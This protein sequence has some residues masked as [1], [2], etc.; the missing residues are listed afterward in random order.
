M[1]SV[2]IPVALFFLTCAGVQAQ[3]PSERHPFE[4]VPA[5]EAPSNT[6]EFGSYDARTGYPVAL[7]HLDDHTEGNT[8]ELR[9]KYWLRQ[10]AL[11]LGLS[12]PNLADL[13]LK[14]VRNGQ[15]GSNV[16][17][18]QSHLGLPVHGAEVVVNLDRKG[19]V[20]FVSSSY[21]TG[22][23][24]QLLPANMTA[25]QARA[26]A[27]N[28][29]G[30]QGPLQ[31]DRNQQVV[32]THGDDVRL[33][34]EVRLVGAEPI[35]DWEAI[36]DANTG[37]F[38]VLQDKSCYLHRPEGQGPRPSA[39]GDYPECDAYLPPAAMATGTGFV[40]D[41]DPLSQVATAYAGAYVDGSDA[42]NA[43]LNAS[44]VSRTLNDITLTG[45]TYSLEGPY[46]AIR[47]FEAPAKGLFAQASPT[48]NFD[49]AA[50]AFEGVNTY[51][52]IDLSMRYLNATLG[53]NV[54]P[55][56][57]ATGVQF[58]AHGLNGAD[59]S[60][61]VG[62]TGRLAFGEGGVDDAE[63]SDVVLHE[64]GHGLHDWITVGGLSN[65]QG[66][67]EGTGDYWTMSHSRSLAQWTTAQAAYHWVFNWDG[68][69]PFWGGRITNY[70]AVYPGGLTGAI[71]T[72]GQIWS[73][74][75]MKIYD[76]IG[77]APTDVALWEGLAMT[78]GSTNQ[79]SAAIA[80]RQAAINMGYTSTQINTI[81]SLLSGCG[82]VLP[83]ILS[84]S[85]DEWTATRANPSEVNLVWSTLAESGNKMFVVERRLE[86]EADFA[87]VARVDGAGDANTKL[88]Y[89][90][91]DPNAFGGPS[92]Y[93]LR[94]IDQDGGSSLS[95]TRLVEGSGFVGFEARISPN[96]SENALQLQISH[97]H[98]EPIEMDITLS[99]LSGRVLARESG[100]VQGTS[101]VTLFQSQHFPAGVYQ[102]AVELDGQRNVLRWV[103]R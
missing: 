89:S 94:F 43:S 65:V 99:D 87:E 15:S 19:N 61:Y 33:A 51:Y 11:R 8:P 27:I 10:N 86:T 73:T 90:L 9:A 97:T 69:N 32:W 48:F 93:R 71:H 40:F 62:G 101:Q 44:R 18:I 102:V 67:S 49:R 5:M 103:K 21:A 85:L 60:H 96:P 57:Y 36:I 38:V 59:N 72:D 20:R 7:Y 28:W 68:H 46:A 24:D 95:E 41:A 58:D 1:A 25:S 98:A 30:L 6:T 22:L 70:G 84:A 78:N 39:P 4:I 81:S 56:Q 12:D 53:V 37:E 54:M 29:I 17:F 13:Q 77:R 47:E 42:A 100:V 14:H 16:R 45:A 3:K 74:C 64:L 34:W 83:A 88:Q 63:D 79:Q 91:K 2:H 23:P 76:A 50:D 92:Y 55:Y 26:Q 66:L 75:M 52:F 82:Y 35:G 80:V 31:L